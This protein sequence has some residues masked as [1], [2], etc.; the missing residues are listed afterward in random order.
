MFDLGADLAS[1][2]HKRNRWRI[3]LCSLLLIAQSNLEAN[4]ICVASTGRSYTDH[5]SWPW[6]QCSGLRLLACNLVAQ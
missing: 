4:G 3:Y 5:G 6:E 2:V 1:R